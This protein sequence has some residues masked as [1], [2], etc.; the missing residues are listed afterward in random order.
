MA[1]AINTPLV[2]S[3]LDI[4]NVILRYLFYKMLLGAYYE[5]FYKLVR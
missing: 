4:R 5:S 2:S 1:S 3:A